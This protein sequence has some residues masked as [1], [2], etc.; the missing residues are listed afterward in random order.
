LV[1]DSVFRIN[2]VRDFVYRPEG[3]TATFILDE[4]AANELTRIKS[5]WL[6]GEC[7]W[8]PQMIKKA[9]IELALKLD[10]TVLQAVENGMILE[11]RYTRPF[12]YISEKAHQTLSMYLQS[13]VL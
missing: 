4:T 7:E 9:V 10:K 11:P 8:T 12:L 2:Y 6:T 3:S 1:D 5:P 13:I